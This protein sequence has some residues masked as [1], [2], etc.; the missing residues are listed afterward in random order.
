[1]TTAA[2]RE[3]PFPLLCGMTL[4]GM[5]L[6]AGLALHAGTNGF[7]ARLADPLEWLYADSSLETTP[8]L[9]EIDIPLNGVAEAN[10]LLCGLDADSPLSLRCDAEGAEWFR[11]KPVP[12]ERNTG[13]DGM[14]EDPSRGVTNRF[15]TRRAPFRVYD[16]MEPIL[17]D[18]LVPG[19]QAVALRVRLRGRLGSGRRT[20]V[21]S[22]SQGGRTVALPFKIRVHD[23]TVPPVGRDGFRYTNWIDWYGAMRCHGVRSYWSDSHFDVIA[24]YMRLAAYGRQNV[25]PVPLFLKKDGDTDFDVPDQKLYARFVDLATKEGFFWLEGSHL[26]GFSNGS[27][28][29]NSFRPRSRWRSPAEPPAPTNTT[30]SIEGAAR[31]ARTASALAEM[32]ERRGWR[33]R[34][35]QHVSDEPST[36]NAAEYR[37]TAGIVRKYMPGIRLVDAIE[38]PDLA[39]AL[40]VYCPKNYKYELNAADYEALRTRD[41]DEIWCYTCNFPGG[42]W[43][44]R[45]LDQELVR[46]L[47][48]PLGCHLFSLQGYLHWGLNRYSPERTPFDAGF[49]GNGPAGDRNIVYPGPDGPWP[50]VRLEAMRQGIEDFELLKMLSRIDRSAA[51]RLVRRVVRGFG[52]YTTR[53]ADYRAMRRALLERLSCCNTATNNGGE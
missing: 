52:D 42:K 25:M 7:S 4:V 32:I 34:W 11:M 6:C 40:D 5:S 39:G 2:F 49:S 16:A 48:I 27:W 26:C 22:L 29:D 18:H 3:K 23:V 35:L 37:I 13:P 15:V 47:Y 10:V 43:M 24:R 19:A 28:S 50:S 45:L 46:S 51:D 31:L 41:T 21:F 12:V 33:E 20:V 30:T 1:M 9:D 14:L 17:G 8:P 44:N 38:I 53:V 36:H